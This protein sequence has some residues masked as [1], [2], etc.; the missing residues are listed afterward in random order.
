ME[1]W[2]ENDRQLLAS[3][4]ALRPQRVKTIMHVVIKLKAQSMMSP[5]VNAIKHDIVTTLKY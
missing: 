3:F 2:G 4:L 1:M 5:L